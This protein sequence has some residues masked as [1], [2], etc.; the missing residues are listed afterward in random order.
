MSK[1]IP[2]SKPAPRRVL[3]G[4]CGSLKVLDLVAD[5]WT[6]LVIYALAGGTLRYGELQ[7]TVRGVSQK[8]LTQTLRALE[9]DG[10]VRRTV[11]PV[12]PP[13]VEYDLTP[14]GRTLIEP[15]SALCHW[16]E[17]HFPEVEKAR[18]ARAQE[19]SAAQSPR[20]DGHEPEAASGPLGN[21]PHS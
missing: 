6:A 11:Y 16:A 1:L 9:R 18:A 3:D 14:L 21:N 8:M 4:S 7:R 20:P 10:L 5:K 12:V 13:R 19:P 17:R 2:A 15:L